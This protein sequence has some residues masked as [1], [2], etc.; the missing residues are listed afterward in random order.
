MKNLKIK[1]EGDIPENFL[2]NFIDNMLADLINDMKNNYPQIKNIGIIIYGIPQSGQL[3]FSYQVSTYEI[4][5]S[6]KFY[7]HKEIFA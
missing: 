7:I 5:K 6:R 4:G 2:N 1:I 3:S